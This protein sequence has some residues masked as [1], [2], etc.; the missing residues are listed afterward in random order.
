MS[1]QAMT[2]VWT[3][4]RQSG[5]QLLLLIALA[6][7]ANDEGVCWPS[8][9]RLAEK[10][11]SSVRQTQRHLA[12][13]VESGELKIEVCAGMK[14][15]NGATNRYTVIFDVP[16]EG[17]GVAKTPPVAKVSPVSKTPPDGCHSY[18]TQS[19]REPKVITRANAL[20]DGSPPPA[21][22]AAEPKE[23]EPNHAFD[24]WRRIA[25]QVAMATRSLPRG[26]WATHDAELRR[27]LRPGSA[28]QDMLGRYGED[29]VIRLAVFAWRE[30]AQ[31]PS[32]DSVAA[33]H[34][35]LAADLAES[36]A[37]PT[38]PDPDR[39]S[40]KEGL[41]YRLRDVPGRGVIPV[42]MDGQPFDAAA[43]FA[44]RRLEPTG[45]WADAC[46]ARRTA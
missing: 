3:H 20:G 27:F 36:K 22:K 4:S 16:L 35:K 19:Q 46:E 13:L 24:P 9:P 44:S 2:H 15:S 29:G 30:W 34:A 5:V 11:R 25:D 10:I 45:R 32:W 6:D 23:E 43:W 33:K 42:G 1:M 31:A 38:G 39:R 21:P 14:L 18:V 40:P 26:E 28:Q 8:L 12:L 7:Q 17:V 41:D 37:A